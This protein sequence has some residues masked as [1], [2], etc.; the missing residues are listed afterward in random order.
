MSDTD[1]NESIEYDKTR[2]KLYLRLA[3]FQGGRLELLHIGVPLYPVSHISTQSEGHG[4]GNCEVW[5]AS[6]TCS[7]QR[8]HT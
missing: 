7:T 3:H 6:H 1:R 8:F 4:R 2:E 5:S